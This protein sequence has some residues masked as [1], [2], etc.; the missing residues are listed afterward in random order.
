MLVSKELLAGALVASFLFGSGAAV[1]VEK[2]GRTSIETP[3]A[4]PKENPRS[5]SG[6]QRVQDRTTTR[7]GKALTTNSSARQVQETRKSVTRTLV[8]K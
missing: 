3:K 2:Q 4:R 6:S 5:Q 8:K 7:V 1:A